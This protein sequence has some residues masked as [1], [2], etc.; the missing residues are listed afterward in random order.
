M[1]LLIL[2][3]CEAY[4]SGHHDI[5]ELILDEIRFLRKDEA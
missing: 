1:R 2:Q 5:A 3:Y 4:N